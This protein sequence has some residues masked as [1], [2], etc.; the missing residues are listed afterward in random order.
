MF[1]EW[2]LVTDPSPSDSVSVDVAVVV[3]TDAFAAVCCQVPKTLDSSL[4]NWVKDI[5]CICFNRVLA[6]DVLFQS[7]S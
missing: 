6:I 2:D 3:L 1:L 4:R 5:C 7:K